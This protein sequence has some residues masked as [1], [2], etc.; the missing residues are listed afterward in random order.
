MKTIAL[1]AAVAVLALAADPA[2]ARAKRHVAARCVDR[3]IE[4]SW[5]LVRPAPRPNGCTP[6]VYQHNQ[7][8]GQDP[9]PN[10]RFQLLCDPQTG[11]SSGQY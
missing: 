1:I 6:P 4:F 11:F 8:V 2:L 5:A 7:F 3:P 9:D 10:I